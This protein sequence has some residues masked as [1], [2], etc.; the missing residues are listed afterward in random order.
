MD[1]EA[2]DGAQLP[3][4]SWWEQQSLWPPIHHHLLLIPHFA[5]RGQILLWHKDIGIIV[6]ALDRYGCKICRNLGGFQ[7]PRNEWTWFSQSNISVGKA[8]DMS[9]LIRQGQFETQ[10]NSARN[11]PSSTL[12]VVWF[13]TSGRGIIVT[14][15]TFKHFAQT[16]FFGFALTLMPLTSGSAQESIVDLVL[17]SCD[18]E[19]VDYCSNVTPGRGRIVACLYA[20]NDKLSEQCSLAIE[21][22]VV[23]LN[24]ILSAVSYVV[25]ECQDDLDYFCG[26]VEIGGGQMYQCMSNNRAELEPTCKAAFE[27]AEEDLQ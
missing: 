15:K 25:N 27:Q 11:K 10:P 8:L 3:L 16:F 1:G 19:L 26:D 20:H 13:D 7:T 6:P 23:Q 17:N 9:C 22:G 21:I 4:A 5:G 12:S 18:T 14:I 2:L 24:M